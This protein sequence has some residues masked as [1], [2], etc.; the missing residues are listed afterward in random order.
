M[1]TE[2]TIVNTEREANELREALRSS[3]VVALD[4]EATAIPWYH[5]DYEILCVA[6]S[7]REGHAYVVP[8]D[9]VE[10]QSHVSIHDIFDEPDRQPVWVMQNGAYDYVALREY[11]ITLRTPWEDTLTIQYLLDVEAP[12]GLTALVQ[13]WLKLPPWK[14]IDYKHPELEPLDKLA[15]LCGRDADATL[16]VYYR[17]S[18]EIHADPDFDTMYRNLLQPATTALCE[19]EIE[20]VTI[21]YSRLLDLTERTA[22]EIE[23]LILDIRDMAGEP[24]LNPNSTQQLAKLL[25]GKLG[26]PVTVFTATGAPSTGAEALHNIQGQHPII[27]KILQYRARRKLL[28]ASLQPWADASSH[29]GRLH[30]RYKPAFVKTGRLSSELPNIQQVPRD[31][32]VRSIFRAP[33]GYEILE[34]DYSQL[35]LR[36][37]AW[38]ANEPTILSAYEDGLDLHQVTADSL[39]VDRQTGKTANFGLLYGAGYRKL[40]SIAESDYG[41]ILSELDAERIRSEWFATYSAIGDFH[42]EAIRRAKETGG[43]RTA[44]GR[45]RPLP[46]IHNV[47]WA[48][49]GNAERQAVNTPVQSVASDITLLMITEFVNDPVLKA[50]D[51]RPYIT[52]HDS[53]L[54][55]IPEGEDEIVSH[56]VDRMENPP[57]EKAFGVKLGVPLVADVKR[58]PSWGEAK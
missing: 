28:T 53:I 29:T 44:F 49:K 9:H 56:I 35:E 50:A 12:K 17:M 4:I 39:G 41:V 25:Y 14:D 3:A 33:R 6:F 2:I 5:E 42:N 26:L 21:D 8:V 19:M 34:V 32:E 27:D 46:D 10:S 48:L 22:D 23:H 52:V 36:I 38:L 58:G 18:H 51:V 37:V 30:P 45:W 1:D 57:T 55:L 24:K 16:R 43:V 7:T 15:T 40:R 54:F 13:R 47:E 31:K 11:G 20:G